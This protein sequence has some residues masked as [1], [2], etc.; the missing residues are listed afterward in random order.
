MSRFS[1]F[2]RENKVE[3][4]NGFYCSSA[5]YKSGR[6]TDAVIIFLIYLLERTFGRNI[7][8][9]PVTGTSI[10]HSSLSP[11]FS[12]DMDFT[13]EDFKMPETFKDLEGFLTN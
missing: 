7:F 5:S 6:T 3:K 1:K 8:G 13:F 9:F 10:V 2:M 11:S 12:F 4:E